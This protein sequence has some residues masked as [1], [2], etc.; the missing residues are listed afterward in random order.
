VDALASR[1]MKLVTRDRES[2]D[3]RRLRDALER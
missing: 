2:G 3:F 1:L